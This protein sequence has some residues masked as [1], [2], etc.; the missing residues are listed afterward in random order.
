M[1]RSEPPSTVELG[2]LR[3]DGAAQPLGDRGPEHGAVGVGGLLAEEHEVGALALERLRED[4]ARR[5]EIRARGARVGDEHG[6]VGA[7]RER[8]A[9]RVGGLLGPERDDDDLGVGVALEP[10]RL[11]D[12]VRVEV[13]ERPLAGTVEALRAR[14]EPAGPFGDVL[15]ADGDLHDRGRS[16]IP[17]DCHRLR[18]RPGPAPLDGPSNAWEPA[19]AVTKS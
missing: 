2:G 12:G 4:R 14:I 17:G 10:Q 3:D 19:E 8:L 1:T 18:L 7:H 11:L 16:Y 13:V 15:H 9:E 6:A 5:D